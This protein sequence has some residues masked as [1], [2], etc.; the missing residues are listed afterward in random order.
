[1]DAAYAHR[2]TLARAALAMGDAPR[3]MGAALGAWEL[4]PGPQ[5]AADVIDVC[6][7]ARED[8]ELVTRARDAL[9]AITAGRDELPPASVAKLG[10]VA[11][12]LGS[13]AA[14]AALFR[15]ALDGDPACAP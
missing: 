10:D 13:G 2:R 6:H 4:R 3:A 7:H 9:D 12:A 1:V 11:A 8:A 15:Q 5:I 14:A